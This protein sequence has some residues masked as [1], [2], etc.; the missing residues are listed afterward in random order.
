MNSRERVQR[1]IHFQQPDRIPVSHG[2][3]PAA[4]EKYGV[5]L[6]AILSE[7]S[8][9]FGWE[10]TIK[11]KPEQYPAMYR[12]GY[13]KDEFGTQWRCLEGGL[14]G[15]PVGFPL[16]DWEAYDSYQWPE[17]LVGTPAYCIHSA[18]LEGNDERWY[19]RGGVIKFFEQM[20][21]LR[22]MEDLMLDIAL[23]PHEFL[24]L[25]ED[26][27]QFNLRWIDRW[28]ECE[29]DG[30]V[31]ADDWGSQRQMLINPKIWRKLFKPAYSEMFRKVKDAG[32]NVHLHSDGMIVD[33]IP[34]LI[35]IGVDVL[36]CQTMAIGL[37]KLRPF[38]GKVCFRTDLDRQHI[39]PRGSPAQVKEHVQEVFDA[40]GTV[41]GGIIAYGEISPDVP[42]ANV[43]AMYEAFRDYGN[44]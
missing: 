43:R 40:V 4:L 37:D 5:E 34:D 11:P 31:F 39:L 28:L 41:D 9:D 3:L 21:Q 36:N 6:E 33:I 18:H 15:T 26:M 17:L 7:F 35:E 25:L 29:F 12:V 1:A 2:V 23:I 32:W 10:Y 24:R 38:A 8:D 30:L 27:L 20:E 14:K 13:S 16:A 42:L 44:A 22:G 19:A